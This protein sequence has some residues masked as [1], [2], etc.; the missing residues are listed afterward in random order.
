MQL[1][2]VVPVLNE[3]TS[4][5]ASLARLRPL[6]A[7]GAR[8]IVV[9]GGSTDSTAA[10]AKPQA[11]QLLQSNRGRAQ[12]MNAGAAAAIAG[13]ADVLLF[14]HADSELPDS[15]DRLI[16]TALRTSGRAWGRFDVHI[17]GP[18]ML[19]IV[20]VMM[21]LRSRLTGICTGDQAI[22]V[23]RSAFA[24]LSGFA[25]IALMEDVEFS[26][27]AKRISRPAAIRTRV[28]TSGRR[29]ERH[30]I[31]RTIVLMWR[32]RAA[33]FFGADPQRLAQRYHDAR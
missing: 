12:Q 27:R 6:R 18:S 13:G 11:D 25:P 26:K 21:N 9:D 23:T 22:F 4:I 16:D 33:Y 30:G 14:V 20:S 31:W 17:D 8:V 10:I 29:W 19:T 2:V 3:A 7:R 15:A 24:Q 5:E 28:V 1:A 32:F